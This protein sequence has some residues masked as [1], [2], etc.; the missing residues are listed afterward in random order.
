VKKLSEKQV[1]RA[2]VLPLQLS[3]TG[4]SGDLGPKNK[5]I[6]IGAVGELVLKR[7]CENTR[8]CDYASRA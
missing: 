1:D 8:R 5:N 4:S 3:L 7:L 2:R 6:Q